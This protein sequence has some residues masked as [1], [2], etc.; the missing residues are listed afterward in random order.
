M[1]LRFEDFKEEAAIPG[2]FTG[3]NL[4]NPVNDVVRER[5]SDYIGKYEPQFIRDFGMNESE[6]KSLCEYTSTQQNDDERTNN[7]LA[8]L[9]FSLSCYVAYWWHRSQTLTPIGG[10]VLG[11]EN[12]ERTSTADTQTLLWNQMV[13]NSTCLY[14]EMY[15]KRCPDTEVFR[16][17]NSMGI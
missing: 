17:I 8:R 13:S 9:R 16:T 15:N 5:L 11:S 7:I 6:Y 10:V 3:G 2:L 14:H 1:I 12:G 4:A